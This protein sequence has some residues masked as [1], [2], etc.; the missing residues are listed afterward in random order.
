MLS[1]GIIIPQIPSVITYAP[2]F[3]KTI[4]VE[5]FPNASGTLSGFAVGT[6]IAVISGF[7]S[8]YTEI[9][10]THEVDFWVAQFWLYGFG[11]AFA[12]ITFFFWDGSISNSSLEPASNPLANEPTRLMEITGTIAVI[13]STVAT[14]SV[15]ATIIRKKDNL[16]KLVGPSA[17]VVALAIA[18]CLLF[19]SLREKTLSTATMLGIGSICISTWTYN[20]YKDSPTNLLPS[21]LHLDSLDDSDQEEDMTPEFGRGANS[22]RPSCSTPTPKLILFATAFMLMLTWITS[23]NMQYVPAENSYSDFQDPVD[24]TPFNQSHRFLLTKTPTGV[25][26]LERFFVPHGIVPARWGQSADNE[27]RNSTSSCVTEWI[28]RDRVSPIS[29]KFTDWEFAYLDS[30]CPVYPIPRGGLLFH[31]YWSGKWRPFNEVSI[32]AWLATQRLGDGHRLI[33]WFD[34]GEV[35]NS[36]LRK[37]ATGRFADYVE[38]RKLNRTEEAR[39]TCVANMPEWTSEEYRI[40]NSMKLVSLADITRN[41]LLAKYGGVWIDSDT[42]PMRDLTPLIRSGPSAGGVSRSYSSELVSSTRL[43]CQTDFRWRL[44]Q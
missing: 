33:Y 22:K 28:D 11:T 43:I 29:T 31:Q 14:G 9:S 44:E 13:L 17:G 37:Y 34:N 40:A 25:D 1:V 20:H 10:L 19:P 38:F 5:P 4:D 24:E 42:I 6:L 15:A 7:C 35:P 8:T 3:Q 23:L 27:M 21:S 2:I 18:Q 32:E 39:G 26:D 30:G 12:A 41:L 16:V 36:V